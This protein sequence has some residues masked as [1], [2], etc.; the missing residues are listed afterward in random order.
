MRST[1]AF[2]W[3]VLPSSLQLPEG[4]PPGWGN[5]E[6]AVGLHR[7]AV[8]KGTKEQ[9]LPEPTCE[10][11]LGKWQA[12]RHFAS[13]HLTGPQPHTKAN[14]H[15]SRQPVEPMPHTSEAGPH[16]RAAE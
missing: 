15:Q 2:S 12:Y 1:S 5:P 6:Q 16:P 14:Q 7:P 3:G 13:G 9:K 11:M 10:V 4:P 8:K